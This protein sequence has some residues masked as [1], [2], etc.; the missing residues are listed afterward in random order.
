M[1]IS[2]IATSSFR[3][4]GRGLGYEVEMFNGQ[5]VVY[6]PKWRR[7]LSAESQFCKA[8]L[9]NGYLTERQLQ[10]AVWQYRLGA[11]KTGRVIFWQI[12]EHDEICEGKVMS[13]LP[14]CHRDK[15]HNPTWVGHLLSLRYGWGRLPSRHCFFGLHLLGRPPLSPPVGGGWLPSVYPPPTGSV[16]KNS[17]P[18]TGGVREVSPPSPSS[19]RRKLPSFSLPA[20]RSI[21]GWRQGDWGKS[22][23]TS[24]DHS[25]GVTSSCS[26]TPTRMGLP[27]NDGAMQPT[28]SCANCSGRTPRPSESPPS[29]SNRR[30][31]S[32]SSGKSTSSISFFK[33]GAR[34]EVEVFILGPGPKLK[35]PTEKLVVSYRQTHSFLPTNSI[36]ESLNFSISQFLNILK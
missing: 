19:R 20:I 18:P 2:E 1:K 7:A 15:R 29:W 10:R 28:S 8:L 22:S 9:A 34:S 14:D 36:L 5:L 25:G 31:Q 21:S 4:I 33:S 26:P 35:F 17:S 13:Y 6:A 23:L 3:R 11:T 27:S 12:N 30:R 16:H 24:S 32:K